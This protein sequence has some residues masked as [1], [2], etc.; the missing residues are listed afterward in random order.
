VA[1]ALRAR[2]RS[3]RKLS[4]SCAC[5]LMAALS[6]SSC[7]GPC[8]GV[9]A[10]RLTEP[11]CVCTCACV[12]SD[13]IAFSGFMSE[14]IVSAEIFGSAISTS[15][16]ACMSSGLTGAISSFGF[17]VADA[18]AAAGWNDASGFAVSAA[19]TG[20]GAVI[21]SA[22]VPATGASAS[23]KAVPA[24]AGVCATVSCG[25][26]S[27]SAIKSADSAASVSPPST[28]TSSSSALAEAVFAGAAESGCEA[29]SGFAAS[30]LCRFA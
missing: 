6:I 29:A 8:S 9:A 2:P 30:L 22:S 13:K 26:V 16:S 23:C 11:G 20:T 17:A 15:A 21:A 4:E 24:S 1:S 3:H 28:S 27:P 7:D 5:L 19:A 14:E 18:T 25:G 10:A 12:S